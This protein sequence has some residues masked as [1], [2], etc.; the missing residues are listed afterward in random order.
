MPM[1]LEVERGRLFQV[2]KQE[3][4]GVYTRVIPNKNNTIKKT[5]IQLTQKKPE[6]YNLQREN[7]I[8]LIKAKVCELYPEEKKWR[9]IGDL[10]L[11]GVNVA[12]MRRVDGMKIGMETK[13]PSRGSCLGFCKRKW[14]QK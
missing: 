2:P 10:I 3:K 7:V 14:Q 5:Y 9:L 12:A 4:A 1:L 8:W 11:G 13:K 6:I